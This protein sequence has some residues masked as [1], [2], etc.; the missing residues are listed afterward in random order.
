M[1]RTLRLASPFMHGDDVRAVQRHLKVLADGEYGPATGGAVRAWKYRMGFPRA[2]I[3]TGFGPTAHQI[4]FRQPGEKLPALYA[5]RRLKRMALGWKPGWG[6]PPEP[7]LSEA[8]LQ[9]GRAYHGVTEQPPGSNVVP[10]LSQAGRELHSP[11]AGMGWAWCAYFAFL[12]YLAAGSETAKAGLVQLRFNA[13]YTPT[14]L[15]CAERGEF[16]LTIVGRSQARPGDLVMFNFPGGDPRVDHIGLLDGPIN[17]A[18]GT[19]PSLEGNTSAGNAGSQSNGGGVWRRTDR[20]L[21]LVTAF[22]RIAS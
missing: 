21:S 4:M 7:A 17:T 18:A 15:A 3:N 13:L 8:A 12:C 1:P 14:I 9:W 11:H 6:L 2:A 16:G 20:S 19:F 5:G 22:I 10:R